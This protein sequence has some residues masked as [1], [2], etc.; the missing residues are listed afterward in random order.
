MHNSRR[1]FFLATLS[2][3]AVFIIACVLPSPIATLFTTKTPTSTVT[4][5]ITP[6]PTA[7]P[8]PPLTVEPCPHA[9]PCYNAIGIYDLVPEDIQSGVEYNVDVPYDQAVSFHAGWLA[10]N[11]GIVVQNMKNM[12]N[13]MEIDGVNYFQGGFLGTPM[14][15]SIENDPFEYFSIWEGVVLSGW[16]IGQ[17]HRV[18]IG[19]TTTKQITD[20]VN[21]YPSGYVVEYIYN[22]NPIF[23]PTDTPTPEPTLTPTPRPT[24]TY[25]PKPTSIPVTPTSVCERSDSVNISNRTGGQLTIYLSGPFEYKFFVPNGTSPI[26]I[27]PGSL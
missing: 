11:D 19:F 22:V 4:P 12:V 27:C 25:V 9:T 6:S 1:L 10:Q 15:Y 3:I 18:R 21:V 23:R 5:T 17:P 16:Q 14:K 20:G 2:L 26:Y 13:F 7:T 24:N 8:M